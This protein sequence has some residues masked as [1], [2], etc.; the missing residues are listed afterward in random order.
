[1]LTE[2][3]ARAAKPKTKPYKLSDSYRLFLLVNPG[4]GKLWRWSY[5]YD[6][7]EKSMALGAYPVVGLA[8][9]RRKRDELRA[10]LEEGRDPAIAKKLKVEAILEA[11]RRTFETVAREWHEHTK[12]QWARVHADD[13]LRSL[14]RDVFPLIGVLPIAEINAPKVLEV[15]RAIEARGAIETAKRVRQRISATFVYAIAQG[16]RLDDP[17]EKLG[18]VL[19][20]LRKG[21][22]PAITDL[23]KLQKMIRD[24]EEDNARP[25]TRFAL[26]YLALT[27]VRPNEVHGGAW[28]EHEQLDGPA[29]LWRIPAWRMK[30]DLERKEEIGGDHLV[31]LARQSVDLLRCIA[32]LT[33]EGPYIFPSARNSHRPMSENAIG[34]LLH[35]AGYHGRHVPHGFRAAFS[36][37]MNE[38]AERH[39]KEHDREVIDL[40]LAHVPKNKIEGAYNRAAYMPRRRELAQTWADL[41]CEG[42]A[43]RAC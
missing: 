11:A 1:M 18:A 14:E 10:V 26:R 31:P 36:T 7:K 15:L 27:V 38:W 6:G 43:K 39:G 30:G 5:R 13:V 12:E 29:P 21:R 24:A 2:A 3:K 20:P 23:A 4:G 41:L 19:K 16:W 40:M 42:L 8:D 34:Y 9:A 35:R 32:P 22:Q 33:G 17:A 28:E 25:V 37:I